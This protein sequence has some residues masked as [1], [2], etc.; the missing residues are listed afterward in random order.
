MTSPRLV[1]QELYENIR[2]ARTCLVDWTHWRANVFFELG[3]RLACSSIDPV[4]MLD[5]PDTTPSIYHDTQPLKQKEDL[6]RL[7]FPAIY[8]I[9]KD[10]DQQEL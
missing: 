2:L 6:I 8:A 4:C 10:S 5:D 7:F 3:V 9:D 1:G